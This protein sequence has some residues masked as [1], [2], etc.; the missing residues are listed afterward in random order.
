MDIVMVLVMVLA[1]VLY[2]GNAGYQKNSRPR[3]P[4]RSLA[5]VP[6]AGAGDAAAA[7]PKV[8]E[9]FNFKFL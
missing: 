9:L 4:E 8:L 2:L 1:A 7:A 6:A 5:G 3:S